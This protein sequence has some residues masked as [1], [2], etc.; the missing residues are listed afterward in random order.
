MYFHFFLKAWGSFPWAGVMSYEMKCGGRTEVPQQHEGTV[1]RFPLP[2]SYSSICGGLAGSLNLHFCPEVLRYYIPLETTRI[3]GKYAFSP[4]TTVTWCPPFFT[5]TV[6]QDH[7]RCA[8]TEVY[9][10]PQTP[11]K[12]WKSFIKNNEENTKMRF[13]NC[14]TKPFASC[15]CILHI[16]W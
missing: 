13:W 1:P 2:A 7:R 15:T 4:Q 3:W 5:H 14:K 11:S 6:S 9:R 10:I 8:K 16:N 12:H